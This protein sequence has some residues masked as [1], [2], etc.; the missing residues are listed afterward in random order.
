LSRGAASA[1]FI[2]SD[3]NAL[4]ALRANVAACKAQNR[5]QILAHDVFQSP[6]G[7]GSPR[8]AGDASPAS[9]AI[10]KDRDGG[11]AS[12]VFLDP[13]YGQD[14]VPRA[15]VRLQDAGRIRH[16]ALIVAETA[17]DETWIPD[18]PLLAERQHG[19]A[20]ILIFRAG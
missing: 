17:K 16:G 10:D 6:G 19:A 1:N 4:R 12:L 20:R 8:H 11:P 15:L 7:T 14:F 18:Q 9:A 2:E 13:P 3:A 5:T